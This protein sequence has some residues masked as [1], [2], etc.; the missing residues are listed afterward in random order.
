MV[1]SFALK[2]SCFLFAISINIAY[3][4]T[5]WFTDIESTFNFSVTVA[6]RVW[7]VLLLFVTGV[8][9]GKAVDYL[10]SNGSDSSD[11]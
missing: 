2:Y 5:G 7:Q 1:I 9:I 8:A 6:R 4:W 3:K 11:S 10:L